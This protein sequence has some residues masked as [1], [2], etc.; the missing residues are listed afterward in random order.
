MAVGL[1]DSASHQY[2]MSQSWN[3]SAWT[4]SPVASLPSTTASGLN[5][6]SCSAATSCMAVGV[7]VKT[8]VFSTFPLA[9]QWNGTSWTAPTLGAPSGSTGGDLNGVSCVS[10]IDCMTVGYYIDTYEEALA[11]LYS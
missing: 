9:E 3:G 5:Q 11:E 6:V 7:D 1:Y 10:T 8:G 2:A 4:L